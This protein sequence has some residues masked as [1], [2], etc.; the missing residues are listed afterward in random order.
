MDH[1]I[2]SPPLLQEYADTIHAKGVPLENCSGFID[3]TVRP[4]ARPDQ[5]QR[6][7]YNGYKPV[8][9]VKVQ[10]VALPNGLFVLVYLMKIYH[11]YYLH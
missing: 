6:I 4:I 2:L 10:S 7:V 5:W 1:D 8:H 9:S 3:G 11:R